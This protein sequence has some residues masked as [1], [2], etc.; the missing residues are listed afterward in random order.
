MKTAYDKKSKR[1]VYEIFAGEYLAVKEDRVVLKTLLGSCVAVCLRD[2]IHGISGI[3]HFMLPGVNIKR[4][5]I[6]SSDSRYGMH[7]MELLIN[8]MI[9][10]GSSRKYMKAKVFGGASVLQNTMNDIASANV[11]FIHKYL[12]MEGISIESFDTGGKRGRKIYYLPDSFTVFL[13][14][15]ESVNMLKRTLA[16]EKQYYRNLQQ[17]KDKSGEITL[18]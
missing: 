3:N 5:I 1:K 18:F 9:K 17:E 6:E 11:E 12:E 13:K 2:T 16:E 15:I 7:A 4:G 14:R 10:L 8:N